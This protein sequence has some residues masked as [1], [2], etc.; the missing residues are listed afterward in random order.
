MSVTERLFL[1]LDSSLAFY[2]LH[3]V[4]MCVLARK[5]DHD[6]TLRSSVV[7]LFS[8]LTIRAW[9]LCCFLVANSERSIFDDDDDDDNDIARAFGANNK[10]TDLSMIH[11]LASWN[12][13]KATSQEYSRKKRLERSSIVRFLYHNPNP[14]AAKSPA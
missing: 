14:T 12:D 1:S 9:C 3:G 7:G 4:G 8:P 5:K 10:A 6:T 2:C 13:E 11:N